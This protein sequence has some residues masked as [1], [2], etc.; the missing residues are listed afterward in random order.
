MSDWNDK[1]PIYQQIKLRIE[2][3]IL[4]GIW[5][6]GEALPSVRTVASDLK[7]NH[8]TVM[9]AYQLLVDDSLIE[10]VRG[11]GM[12]VLIGA[13]AQLKA[14][15]TNLFLNEGI[16]EIIQ[17]LQQLEIPVDDFIQALKQQIKEK[18]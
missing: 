18:Q 15:K 1:Q 10:K 7:I 14:H 17:K 11:R 13:Q 6:E 5:P 16:P 2:L 8:L 12:F 3:Q 4:A 9:K